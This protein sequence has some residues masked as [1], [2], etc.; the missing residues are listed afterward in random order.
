VIGF[1]I[2]N[3]TYFWHHPSFISFL[4]YQRYLISWWAGTPAAKPLGIW[5]LIFENKWQTWWGSEAVI[6]VDQWW[7]GWPFF[8]TLGLLSLPAI[9]LLSRAN[10][11]LV[12]LYTFLVLN[13]G[14]F[15]LSLVFPRY[16][17]LI[18]PVALVL[19]IRLIQLLSSRRFSLS[20]S[21]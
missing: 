10:L 17:V 1:L 20:S 14:L 16:L 6:M 13:L 9:Y 21:R 19:T 5:S 4:K 18:M 15:S 11:G 3:A 7:L 2:G 8:I 12:S